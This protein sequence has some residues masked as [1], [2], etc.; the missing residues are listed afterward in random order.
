MR[1]EGELKRGRLPLLLTM[2]WIAGVP[3]RVFFA[4]RFPAAVPVVISLLPVLALSLHG[5][6]GAR[7]TRIALFEASV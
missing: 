2:W 6:C 3:T 5:P 7:R 1:R 4:S